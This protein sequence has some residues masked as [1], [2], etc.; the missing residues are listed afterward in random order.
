[1]KDKLL[2][3]W[4]SKIDISNRIKIELLDKFK[5]PKNIWD[6]NADDFIFYKFSDSVIDKI[7]D[8]N[9]RQ[10]LDKDLDF[11]NKNNISVINCF[12]KKYPRKTTKNT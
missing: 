5:N 10:N 2:W 1:M 4:L 8:L 6:A 11:M 7:M 9:F 3:I 12:D